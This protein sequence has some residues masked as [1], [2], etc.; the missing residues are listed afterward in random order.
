MPSDRC[1][2][3]TRDRIVCN[4]RPER[5]DSNRVRATVM[6]NMVNHPGNNSTPTVDL[7][8]VNMLLNSVV[9]TPG[10]KLMTIDINNFYLDTPL[11][12]YEYIEHEA[13]KLSRRNCGTLQLERKINERPFCLC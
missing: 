5:E 3:V 1:K 8:T 6:G 7:L 12:R 4:V 10:T 9:S 13:L 11:N 2:D